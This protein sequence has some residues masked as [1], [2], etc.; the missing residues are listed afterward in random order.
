MPDIAQFTIQWCHPRAQTGVARAEYCAAT[1][2]VFE[3]GDYLFLPKVQFWKSYTL[4]FPSSS[5]VVSTTAW[6]TH[7]FRAFPLHPLEQFFHTP[8]LPCVLH[9]FW[10][11]FCSDLSSSGTLRCSLCSWLCLGSSRDGKGL[12]AMLVWW[13][14][15]G[16]CWNTVLLKLRLVLGHRCLPE[17]SGLELLGLLEK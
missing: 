10:F 2:L 13:R 7:E 15:E 14:W 16:T 5:D 17:S 1:I 11:L 8:L 6:E 9:L 12:R 3:G 4:N